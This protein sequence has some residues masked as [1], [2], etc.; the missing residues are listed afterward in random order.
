MS[1]K[2]LSFMKYSNKGNFLWKTFD[3]LKIEAFVSAEYDLASKFSKLQP[4]IFSHGLYSVSHEYSCHLSE[5]A[6]HG[7]I[8][9]AINHHDG[10]CLFTKDKEGKS[11]R[12]GNKEH[13][14]VYEFDC[15]EI[16]DEN[17]KKA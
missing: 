15:K 6:S 2:R 14:E 11:Y 8:V 3:S 5:L 4:I 7:Y 12:F 10:S 9:F 16:Y 13:G 1:S 17:V